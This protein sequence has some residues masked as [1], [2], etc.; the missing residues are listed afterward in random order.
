MDGEIV[1]E[2]LQEWLCDHRH[3]I[4][5]SISIALHNHEMS[6]S[7]WFRYINDQS[8]PDELALYSLSHKHSTHTSV[9]NKSYVWTMLMNHVNRSDD[10]II[11]LSGINLVYLGATTYGIIRNIRSPHPQLRPNPAPPKTSGH[12]SKHASKVT[13]RSGS[14]SRKT[15]GKGSTGLGHGNRGKASRTLSKSRKENYGITATNVTPHSVRSSR[16]PVDYVSLNDGYEDETPSPSIKRCKESHRP[17]SAPSATWLSAHKCKNSPDS[18]ALDGDNPTTDAFTAIPTLAASTL[19]GVP[20]TDRQLPDLVLSPSG[21]VPE[22]KSPV[23][24]GNTEEDL[25]ATS[26]LLSLGDTLED[27]LD[28]GDENALLM[29]IGGANVPEDVVPQP[30]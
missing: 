26:T 17:R 16:Q 15:A 1:K 9:F 22:N 4:T 24:V 20:N 3:K 28:E 11:S 13:C 18:T 23:N 27:M 7:E 21:S 6:Y 2:S 30:L 25:E 14:H 5:Q 29:Q 8:G 19:E 10:E 12:T